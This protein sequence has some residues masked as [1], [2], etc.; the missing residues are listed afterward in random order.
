MTKI[1][2]A[3]LMAL[4]ILDRPIPVKSRE[5]CFVLTINPILHF[6]YGHTFMCM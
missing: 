4:K 2:E 5:N 6:H 3:N 1:L